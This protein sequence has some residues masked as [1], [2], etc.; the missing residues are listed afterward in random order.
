MGGGGGGGGGLK[1][2]FILLINV[3]NFHRRLGRV[4]KPN[5]VQDIIGP[6]EIVCDLPMRHRLFANFSCIS[7]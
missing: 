6:A 1:F 7:H 3:L 2:D 5:C 4:Y